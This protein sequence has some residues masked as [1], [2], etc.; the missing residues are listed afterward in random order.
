MLL[1]GLFVLFRV[2][3]NALKL[4]LSYFSLNITYK[5]HRLNGLPYWVSICTTVLSA[6]V[7]ITSVLNCK[8]ASFIPVSRKVMWKEYT[9]CCMVP[10]N[11]CVLLLEDFL[12]TNF[13]GEI[14]HI[15]FSRLDK[16]HMA[17]F[18]LVLAI[19]V[20]PQE[21]RTKEQKWSFIFGLF[22]NDLSYLLLSCTLEDMKCR[23]N[24][25]GNGWLSVTSFLSF[26]F[27]PND[28][29]FPTSSIHFSKYL[30]LHLIANTAKF[31]FLIVI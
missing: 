18:I 25:C 19:N 23:N 4:S 2:A 29:F 11:G 7:W 17:V 28:L 6:T 15:T 5:K 27:F 24:G 8:C 26:F 12:A 20:A 16:R 3:A 10:G 21:V 13:C 31:C 9:C 14:K 30:W 22:P 1:K